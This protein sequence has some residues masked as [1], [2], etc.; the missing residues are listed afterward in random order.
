MMYAD[1]TFVLVNEI[2]TLPEGAAF[3]DGRVLLFYSYG[4]I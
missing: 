2:M 3:P 4:S 1:I